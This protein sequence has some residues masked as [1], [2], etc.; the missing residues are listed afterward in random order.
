MPGPLI[1][2]ITSGL[3]FLGNALASRGQRKA[4]EAE[5][6]AQLEADKR[7]DARERDLAAADDARARDL[8]TAG[9]AADE[10]MADP[11]RQQ[12]AQAGAIGR[13]DLM[14]RM[15]GTNTFTPP[16]E[17]ASYV[18]QLV[19]GFSYTPSLDARGSAAALKRNIMAGNTAP[20]MTDPANYGRT[21]ALNLLP[22]L[23]GRRDPAEPDAFEPSYA[24]RVQGARAV[25]LRPPAVTTVEMVKKKKRR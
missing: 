9:L 11:F 13:L 14:E 6:A 25:Q 12:L 16:P 7:R 8:N 22:V 2:L 5:L 21:A 3:S 24:S 10:S 23:A 17:M 4:Q 18:P 19:G 20:T 1:P 15:G